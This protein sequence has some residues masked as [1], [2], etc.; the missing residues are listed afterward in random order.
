[1]RHL[2]VPDTHRRDRSQDLAPSV[3]AAA[4]RVGS[5]TVRDLLRLTEH[6]DVISLAGGLPDPASFP[7]AEVADAAARVLA[8]DPAVL[9]YA[10]TEGDPGLRRWILDA[11]GASATDDVLITHG[12]Q[13]ALDLIVRAAVAPGDPVVVADPAYVGALQVLRL[14]GAHV[15]GIP[16][17]EGGL[18]VDALAERLDTG[19]RPRLVYTVSTFHNPT[20]ATLTEGRRRDLAT[21][22]ERHGFLIVDD[23]PYRD[24][25]WAG[26]RPTPLAA[27]TERVITLG[28]FSK[29]VSPGLRVGYAVGRADL[30]GD[31]TILKQAADLQTATLNQAVVREVVTRP[32][33]LATH[34]ASVCTTYETR[35]DALAGALREHLGSGA[36]FAR[37][38]GGMFL[39]VELAGGIDTTALL[40][41]ATDRG[42]AFVPGPAFAVERDAGSTLRLSFATATPESLAEAARRLAG[43][44]DE[45]ASASPVT[46]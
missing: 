43:A 15:V 7:V 4:E 35:A 38:D 1:M 29:V 28:S 17:D 11:R 32:G 40:P 33:W 18:D 9:Q 3:Q 20:G 45:L 8:D 24:L 25:R 37:P 21:L 30:I 12:S 44:V 22:A 27:L 2:L 46:R 10:P 36:T 41:L 34:L 23:D 5:S 19:L 42:V 26:H 6:P 13:Q 16:A 39:W 31:L 14:A